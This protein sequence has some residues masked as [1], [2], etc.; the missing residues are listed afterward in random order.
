MF[1]TW[2]SGSG[3]VV[4]GL[5]SGTVYTFDT[6][7]RNLDNVETAFGAAGVDTTSP[8]A[9]SNVTFTGITSSA[10]NVNWTDNSNDEAG[11]KVYRSLTL[12]SG[13][14]LD[15]SVGAG[16]TVYN[17]TGLTINTTYYWRVTAYNNNGE[18][19][20]ASGNATTSVNTPGS[21]T[22]S[23]ASFTTMKVQFD[24][25]SNPAS[26]EYAV[27]F[28][29]S[30]G[31]KYMHTSGALVDTTVW[32][33][34]AQFGSTAGKTATG[35]VAATSYTAD[36]KARNTGKTET[37]YGTSATLSTLSTTYPVTE[38]FDG[39]TFPPTNWL[40]QDLN[41]GTTWVRSTSAPK[42]GVGH[43]SY[44]YS[45]SLPANDWLFTLPLTMETGKVYR[46][47]YWYRASSASYPENLSVSVG[48]GQSAASMTSVLKDYASFVNT[49]YIN[50]SVDYTPT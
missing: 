19:N 25:A 35:L 47:S 16:V 41:A 21:A 46:V 34:Y 26:V 42:S 29:S 28:V 18:S 10:M 20:F 44:P 31:T 38:S 9:P 36:V 37:P 5:T 24:S 14:A 23:N 49:T 6:K 32:G 30:L 43:A 13:Y 40:V 50:D 39:V 4:N 2:G 11:F 1:A 22:L 33:T 7:A 27:R 15:G 48:T 3:V 45:L 8:N 12:N 17:A